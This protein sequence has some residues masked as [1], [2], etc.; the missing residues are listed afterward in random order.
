MPTSPHIRAT[1]TYSDDEN[2]FSRFAGEI[3]GLQRPAHGRTAST[4]SEWLSGGPYRD[5]VRCDRHQPS[6]GFQQRIR[7]LRRRPVRL[8]F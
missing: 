8:R 3:H 7:Q 6:A 2:T 5:R 4:I 1:S